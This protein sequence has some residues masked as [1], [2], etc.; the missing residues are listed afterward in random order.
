M[1]VKAGTK[2]LQEHGANVSRFYLFNICS[3]FALPLC[4]ELE[5][6]GQFN[7]CSPKCPGYIH[8]INFLHREKHFLYI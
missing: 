3:S 1:H 4:L 6:D 7:L 8:N 2:R 5:H